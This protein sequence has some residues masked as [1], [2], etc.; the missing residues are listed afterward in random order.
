MVGMTNLYHYYGKVSVTT[1]A[2]PDDQALSGNATASESFKGWGM[3]QIA[4]GP[5]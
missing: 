2:L 4:K 1:S 5:L 3:A